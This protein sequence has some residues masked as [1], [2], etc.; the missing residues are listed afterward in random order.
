VK[1]AFLKRCQKCEFRLQTGGVI[2]GCVRGW[3]NIV[4]LPLYSFFSFFQKLRQ[5][6]HP[7]R[8]LERFLIGHLTL[9][10][11]EEMPG[12]VLWLQI[13]I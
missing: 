8:K 1:N 9:H 2:H 4:T 10:R 7:Y 6:N 5:S 13:F 3:E 11:D 12:G